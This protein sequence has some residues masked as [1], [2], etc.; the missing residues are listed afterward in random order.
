[1]N[2]TKIIFGIIIV[3]SVASIYASVNKT[4]AKVA[5]SF[6][7]CVVEGNPV[8]ESYPRQCISKNGDHFTENIGNVL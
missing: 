7:E 1:M 5:A 8:M 2:K 6:E 3:V 4:P